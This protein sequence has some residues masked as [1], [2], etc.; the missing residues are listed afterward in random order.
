MEMAFGQGG[1]VITPLEQAV[2]YSTFANGG[3]RYAP[4]V[5]AAVVIPTA[6]WSKAV[7]KVTG[8]VNLSPTNY[9]ALLTGF[10][11]V[12]NDPNGTGY[13]SFVGSGWNQ[14]AFTLGGKTGTASVGVDAW[15]STR[16]DRLVRRVRP[17]RQSA[18]RGGLRD[19]PGRLRRQGIGPGGPEDLRLPGRPSGDRPR[20]AAGVRLGE[21]EWGCASARHDHHHGSGIDHH[22]ARSG[23]DHD[24]VD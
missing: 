3:T 7:P 4:Q 5:A 12:V 18:V 22:H 19:R 10:E 15:K 20:L 24:P 14:A 2:A 11:G 9:Q 6:R 1:T 17:E 23:V 16:A 8:H 13:G 21:L